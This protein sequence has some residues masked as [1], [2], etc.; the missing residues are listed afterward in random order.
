[1]KS[2]FVFFSNFNA[3]VSEDLYSASEDVHFGVENDTLY[4]AVTENPNLA[5]GIDLYQQ[6]IQALASGQTP[7]GY[8]WH[9][10]EQLC[11]LQLVD[12]EAH[13]GGRAILGRRELI[14]LMERYEITEPSIK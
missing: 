10:H 9:H 1:M 3:I 13:I 5:S 12:E 11:H 7:K 8:T 2:F 4:Q 14:S 6:D